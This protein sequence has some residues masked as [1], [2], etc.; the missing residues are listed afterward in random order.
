MIKLTWHGYK[1]GVVQIDGESIHVPR[2]PMEVLFFLMVRRG[3]FCTMDGLISF[4]WPDADKEPDYALSIVRIYIGT[5]RK[6]FGEGVIRT[7][8]ER[9]Y[10]MVR[11]QFEAESD[12]G[13]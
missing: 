12:G 4:V 10:I 2:Q 11:Q 9:G 1:R 6:I 5:L 3:D 13:R 8:Y 7:H